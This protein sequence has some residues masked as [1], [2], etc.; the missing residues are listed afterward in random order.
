[1]DHVTEAL[2]AAIGSFIIVTFIFAAIILVCQHRKITQSR[3]N[4]QIRTRPLRNPNHY[5]TSSN[6]LPVDASWS[7][8]PNLKISME[9]LSRAT[10]DFSP[11]HI[12]GD[13]SFGLV[14][15]ARLSNGAVVAVKKL[16]ADAFQGFREFAAEM[17]TLS[18]LRHQNIVKIRGYW[19][20]GAERLLVYE[21]IEKGN[22]D[23]WL[24][25]PSP[26]TPPNNDVSSSTDLIR[27]PLSWETRVNIMR[28]VAHGLCY[29]HGLEKPIIHR[30]IK[31]SNVLLDSD[32][33]AYIADFGLA[34]RMDK[35]H[36]H[37]STQVAGTTGY[38]PPEYWQGSNVA[39]PKVDVYSFGVL[40]I[41]T[42]AGHRPNL[43]IKLEGT[44]IGLV[45]W[46]R[47]MKERNTEMEMLDVNI[48]REEEN[49]KEESVKEYVHIACMCTNDLQKDR[50]QMAEV[51]KLLDSMPL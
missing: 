4:N 8:D 51:V 15:K 40:M 43:S 37:V 11:D 41:E 26:P 33:Q 13:G 47:K 10:N 23:Q 30:D 22:L 35:S 21:F 2:L 31:A 34:R 14:Y 32:F 18:K 48:P 25:E 50:P 20:S 3:R 28:G 49:L 36:S 44:D 27:S 9:E 29:L 7:E 12:V 24:H 42:M 45:N 16:S 1:M 17:E 6:S 5:P 38:M 39:Y 19:A 46:A